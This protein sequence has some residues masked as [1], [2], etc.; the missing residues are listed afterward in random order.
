MPKQSI[1]IFKFMIISIQIHSNMKVTNQFIN[2]FL[3]FPSES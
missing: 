3:T 2:Q 1:F